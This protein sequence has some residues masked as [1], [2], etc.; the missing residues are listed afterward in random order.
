M[1]DE[2]GIPRHAA[3]LRLV[4]VVGERGVIAVLWYV[5]VKLGER[6]RA[7]DPLETRY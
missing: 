4:V 2:F 7:R 6:L 1:L 5:H 3:G